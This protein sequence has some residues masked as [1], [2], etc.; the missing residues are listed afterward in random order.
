MGFM[1]EETNITTPETSHL[2]KKKCGAGSSRDL[3]MF[4]LVARRA[5]GLVIVKPRIASKKQLDGILPAPL[6]R[7][8][9]LPG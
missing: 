7:L 4:V 8:L 2:F 3:P 6:A 9:V 5:E 1:E